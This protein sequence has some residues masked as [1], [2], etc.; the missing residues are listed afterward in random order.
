MIKL[1]RS[2]F[3]WGIVNEYQSDELAMDDEDK[4][5]IEKAERAA[6]KKLT[7]KKKGSNRGKFRRGAQ[8]GG[9]GAWVPPAAGMPAMSGS[10][11][12]SGYA[13]PYMPQTFTFRPPATVSPRMLGPCHNCNGMGHHKNTCPMRL[14]QNGQQHDDGVLSSGGSSKSSSARWS[15]M[16]LFKVV[17]QRKV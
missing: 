1:D 3:G 11:G 4:K 13:R 14:T 16:T 17:T 8:V 12:P 6:E 10:G 9:G 15:Q 2:E 7:A 5:R